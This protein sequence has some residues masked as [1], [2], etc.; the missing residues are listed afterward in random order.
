MAEAIRAISVRRGYD[1]AN[2]ALVAFGGAGP[3]HACDVADLLGVRT[4]LCPP[5]ASLLSAVG[6]GAAKVERFA[7]RQALFAHEPNALA[8]LLADLEREATDQLRAEGAPTDAI[9]VRRRIVS[10]SVRNS[11]PTIHNPAGS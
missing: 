11:Q 7:E 5:D 6:L 1:P 9:S 8:S 2:Y 10:A 3:Q 4:V